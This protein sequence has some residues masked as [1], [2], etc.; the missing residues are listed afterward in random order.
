VSWVCAFTT[1]SDEDAG[2]A[3]KHLRFLQL[4]A[5]KTG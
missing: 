2:E 5:E 4:H 3:W 1:H